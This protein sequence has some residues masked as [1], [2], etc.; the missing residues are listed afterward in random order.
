M[1]SDYLKP[2]LGD[3]DT[4][5]TLSNH[6]YP[7]PYCGCV[8]AAERAC[9]EQNIVELWGDQGAYTK[10]SD[11]QIAELT[12]AEILEAVNSRNMSKIFMQDFDFTQLLGDVKYD[13]NMRIVGKSQSLL[14]YHCESYDTIQSEVNFQLNTK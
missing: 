10:S 4:L 12:R 11:R 7:E 13:K 9:F 6:F 1:Y 5:E 3:L 2:D 8:A 14:I